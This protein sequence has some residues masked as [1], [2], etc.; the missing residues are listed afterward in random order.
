MHYTQPT[1]DQYYQIAYRIM[2]ISGTLMFLLGLIGNLLNIYIF[3]RWSYSGKNSKNFYSQR[4]NLPL[5]LLT[6]SVSNLI[7][8]IYPL[9]TRIL[10]DGYQFQLTPN[11]SY[12]LCKWRYY[13]LHTFDLLSL[14]CICMAIF[15]RYL[16]TSRK[17]YLREFIPK[18]NRTIFH[19]LFV[20]LLI[21]LHNIPLIIYF[22]VTEAGRCS[23]FS[24]IYSYYYLYVFQ[25][26]LHG[27]VP[28]LFLSI[29]GLLTLK[30]L[31]KL[32]QNIRS[33]HRNI[34]RQLSRMLLL[35]SLGIILSAI[36]NC[37][38][39]FYGKVFFHNQIKYSS[40]F[41]LYHVISSIFYYINP[42]MSF[43][44]LFISTPN[45]RYHIRNLCQFNGSK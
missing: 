33:N 19:I 7:V 21:A 17:V 20:F 16:V 10:V 36:P 15:D 35:I 22:D 9:L 26:C 24:L 41:F 2:I 28:I 4:N 27:V 45:F 12:L 32:N 8:I 40:K 30:Q 29:F 6:S 23:I 34:D 14:A 42:V 37:I 1:N 43:Y 39:N 5:Y 38:E 3:T 11:Q 25:I 44:I 31:R 13:A 18:T